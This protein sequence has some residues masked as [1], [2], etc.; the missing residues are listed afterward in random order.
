MLHLFALL[1]LA[2]LLLAL[3]LMFAL[4]PGT[5]SLYHLLV[6]VQSALFTTFPLVSATAARAPVASSVSQSSSVLIC[7]S[8][9]VT[10]APAE[11]FVA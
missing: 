2:F 7:V 3:L 1:S 5:S 8:Y 9:L 10:A 11:V 6:H 4:K